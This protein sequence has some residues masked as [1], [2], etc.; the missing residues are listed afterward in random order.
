MN[1]QVNMPPPEASNPTAIDTKQSNLAPAQDKDFRIVIMN[2]FKTL[3]EDV[4]KNH[5]NRAEWNKKKKT[6][7]DM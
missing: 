1:K 6:M 3:K 7:Q 5:E 2:M 4:N